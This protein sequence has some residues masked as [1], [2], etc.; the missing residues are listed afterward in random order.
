MHVRHDPMLCP[1]KEQDTINAS[2]NGIKKMLSLSLDEEEYYN[3]P[4]IN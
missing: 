4:L 1:D 3:L 2:P